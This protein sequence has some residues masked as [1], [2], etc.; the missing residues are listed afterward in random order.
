MAK[1]T[2]YS[3]IS[4]HTV[5]GATGSTFSVPKSEDFTDGTWTIYDLAL[6]EIGVNETDKKAYIRIDDEVKE[7]KLV[8]TSS[9]DTLSDTLTSGNTTGAND[10]IV[11]LDRQIKT[12]DT[13]YIQFG[14]TGSDLNGIRVSNGGDGT[15]IP[16]NAFGFSGIDPYWSAQTVDISGITDGVYLDPNM[17]AGGTSIKSED[18][19]SGSYS[20]ISVK[21]NQ[22]EIDTNNI[23]FNQLTGTNSRLLS[24]SP[25]GLINTSSIDIQTIV[26]TVSRT[27]ILALNTS[28][29]VI[30]PR[31]GTNKTIQVIS[32]MVRVRTVSSNYSTYTNLQLFQGGASPT[33]QVNCLGT[34]QQRRYHMMETGFG[35]SL[36]DTLNDDT[37]VTLSVETGNPTGGNS[38]LEVHVMYR[39]ITE[40][41]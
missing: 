3:R 22:I 18:T 11:D 24:V 20:K 10:I 25:T 26:A 15:T 34:T 13:G 40:L 27:E 1:I 39:I 38:T 5:T 12:T 29:K 2:Q 23:K 31:Q 7:I 30:I 9:A 37:D 14:D 35:G 4:H 41:P 32:A 28:P 8:G 36:A 19:I 17:I 21:P 6:S 33:H 16:Q